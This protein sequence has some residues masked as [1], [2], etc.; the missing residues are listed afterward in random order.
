MPAALTGP[1]VA[2]IMVLSDLISGSAAS[3]RSISQIAALAILSDALLYRLSYLGGSLNF[4]ESSSGQP[5]SLD[6]AP[7]RGRR[8]SCAPGQQTLRTE[9]V[10]GGG[11]ELDMTTVGRNRPLRERQRTR[12][13][14]RVVDFTGQDVVADRPAQRCEVEVRDCFEQTLVQGAQGAL[15][16]D[17]QVRVAYLEVRGIIAMYGSTS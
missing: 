7:R 9:R 5:T 4:L 12:E 2:N 10:K 1:L 16:P 15:A 14:T 3:S 6:P 11:G 8:R 17:R 13:R